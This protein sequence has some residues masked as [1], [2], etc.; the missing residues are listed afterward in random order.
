ME[1]GQVLHSV[2]GHLPDGRRDSISEP[3][4]P[5]LD[6][7]LLT[8]AP[9]E[10]RV[11]H[12]LFTE[13]HSSDRIDVVMAFIRRSGIAPLMPALCAHCAAGRRLRV[14]TT[15]YTGSTEARALEELHKAGADIRV[16]YDTTN[17]RLHAKAWLLHRQSGFSTAYIGSS[18][19]THS[20]QISGL[21]WNVRVSGARNPDVIDKVAA[22][23]ESYWHNPD[24][25]TYDRDEFRFRADGSIDARTTRRLGP[26]DLRPEPFQERLWLPVPPCW[27]PH[28]A[29]SR[30][31]G[32]CA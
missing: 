20:A 19:L 14:L 24:F 13:I 29:G 3:L 12:Q 21:E 18:N 7:T 30:G 9:G 6:T 25:R 31:G 26:T 10:P 22:V 32:H 2:V 17:T 23:F 8:N 11:G 27:L 16:S 15:T 4:I 1:F 5:L 28:G